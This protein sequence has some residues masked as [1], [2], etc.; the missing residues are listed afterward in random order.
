MR[1]EA[2]TWTRLRRSQ[3]TVWST[4]TSK[5]P[6]TYASVHADGYG[7]WIHL[8]QVGNNLPTLRVCDT[9]SG[10]Q[11]TVIGPR[12]GYTRVT[13]EERIVE[14][15]SMIRKPAPTPGP[16]ASGQPGQPCEILPP[17]SVV[18]DH[19]TQAAWEDGVARQ[20][21]T[22]SVSH[23]NGSF[24]LSI[25]DREN[26]LVAYISAGTLTAA[27]AD[28]ALALETDEIKWRRD[29]FAKE[30]GKQPQGKK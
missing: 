22:V 8:V 19:L 25:R 10:E 21:S 7:L 3:M 29:P 11:L 20:T 13:L 28:L 12:S 26:G 5:T 27:W 4:R 2:D 15:L 23:A 1:I 30:R 17:G 16:T 14:V 9:T 6:V 24:L 18:L